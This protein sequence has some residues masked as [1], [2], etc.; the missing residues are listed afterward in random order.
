MTLSARSGTAAVVAEVGDDDRL[1]TLAV[2]TDPR[3]TDASEK[4]ALSAEA[5][6]AES[7]AF[8][9]SV[10]PPMTM[11]AGSAY[12]GTLAD[13]RSQLDAAYCPP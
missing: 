1:T 11:I 13:M 10:A 9:G 7:S 2:G 4:G 8:P 3:T 6:V 5:G 12:S